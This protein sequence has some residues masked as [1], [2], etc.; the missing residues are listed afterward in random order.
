MRTIPQQPAQ[1]AAPYRTSELASAHVLHMGWPRGLRPHSGKWNMVEC[2]TGKTFTFGAQLEVAGRL[3]WGSCKQRQ[4]R[5]WSELLR[6]RPG[7]P[8]VMVQG[9]VSTACS[10]A[11]KERDLR[12]A[13]CAAGRQITTVVMPLHAMTSPALAA[14][15]SAPLKTAA[16]DQVTQ[17]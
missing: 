15:I 6:R 7:L 2:S 12:S 11:V 16:A 17:S 4:S 14:P 8:A 13:T 5:G 9:R 3:G 10:T 1:A